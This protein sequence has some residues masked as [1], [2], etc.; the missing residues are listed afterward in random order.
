MSLFFP[1]DASKISWSSKLREKWDVTSF[2][3]A[4]Q[5]RKALV[6]QNRP[7]WTI[8][9]SFPQLHKSEVDTLLGFHADCR[10]SWQ[11]WMYKDFERY[12]VIGKTLAND[13]TGTYQAVIPFA[14]Y[15]EPAA[16][17]DNV[18]MWADGKKSSAFTV[19]G[20]KISTDVIAD[21]IKFDYE[22]YF[23]VVFADSIQVTQI[24]F[25]LYRVSLSLEVVE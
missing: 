13:G 8:D 4:G 16:Y 6:R 11:S 12:A 21:E 5:I 1:L 3:S 20:G 19:D 17:I 9:I 24:F 2:K 22:Y 23:K 18:V 25:D 15:E 10:G 14:S 7:S